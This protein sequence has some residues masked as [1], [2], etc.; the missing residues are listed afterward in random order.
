MFVNG[1][2]RYGSVSRVLT[3]MIQGYFAC[4]E[5]IRA[6]SWVTLETYDRYYVSVTNSNLL[7]QNRLFTV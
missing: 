3:F 5:I 7:A 1:T 6:F 4:T 2:E